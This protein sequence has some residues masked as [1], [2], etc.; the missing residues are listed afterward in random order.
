MTDFGISSKDKD[1]KK[2]RIAGGVKEYPLWWWRLELNLTQ[3]ET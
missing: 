2:P 3:E 1:N